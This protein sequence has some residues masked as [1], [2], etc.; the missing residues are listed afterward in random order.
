MEQPTKCQKLA[1]AHRDWRAIVNDTVLPQQ[2]K[3][4]LFV[5]V[6]GADR[7]GK[8]T[9]VAAAV[10]ELRERGMAVE[11]LS[12]PNRATPVGKLIDTY[13][14]SGA[15]ASDEAIHLLF[16]ANRW[17]SAS[18]IASTLLAGTHIICDRYAHSGIAYSRAKGLDPAWCESGDV[19]LPAPDLLV[20]LDAPP[21]V[22]EKRPG[23]GNERYERRE[24]QQRV[25][26]AYADMRGVNFA[27]HGATAV[28]ESLRWV[29]VDA[30]PPAAEV[31]KDLL[32]TL[33]LE[34][35]REMPEQQAAIS[36]L[37]TRDTLPLK[38]A[39]CK[40]INFIG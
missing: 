31:I 3:R 7:A 32:L 38:R 16:A 1:P 40:E 25:H 37:F 2:A 6:E 39:E 19:G 29:A 18:Y 30:R 36:C 4:G 22:L 23:F 21:A 33:R 24:F 27:R 10:K 14:T 17:E 28:S 5:V 35:L 34:L 15:D 26:E 11:K 9:A 20:F 13:L 12:F 8:S